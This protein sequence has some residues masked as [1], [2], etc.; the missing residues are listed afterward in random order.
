M[1]ADPKREILRRYTTEPEDTL[2][3]A[4]L[5]DKAELCRSRG[6]LQ[7]TRFLSLHECIL[8]EKLIRGEKLFPSVL[9]GGF[10]GAERR[11]AVFFPDYLTEEDAKEQSGVA[12]LR[13][14]F[15]PGTL[16]HRDLLGSLMN[17]GVTRDCI[18]DLLVH[19]DFCDIL[20]LEETAPFLLEN[21]SRAGRETLRLT[22]LSGPPAAV[23]EKAELL[24]DTVASLRLDAVLSS[25]CRVSRGAAAELVSAGRVKLN[26]FECTKAD[27]PVEAGDVLS[28]R[29]YGRVVLQSVEGQSRKGR[30]VIVLKR[31]L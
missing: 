22:R 31:F 29:G 8:A 3:L 10:E 1:K 2:M 7:A 9:W 21:V 11:C 12:V 4:K 14:A 26:D 30:T 19:E 20:C 15:R 6:F 17:A 25:A 28:V 24:R 23:E 5:L 18:G 13:A 27:R 16:T